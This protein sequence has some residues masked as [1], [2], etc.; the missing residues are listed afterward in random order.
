ML[1]PL[2]QRNN[3]VIYFCFRWNPA[4]RALDVLFLIERSN[5]RRYAR[6]SFFRYASLVLK[7]CR[8]ELAA[9]WAC[10]LPYYSFFGRVTT[11]GHHLLRR[12]HPRK[13]LLRYQS[14]EVRGHIASLKAA[15]AQRM[16]KGELPTA[17]AC[18][19]SECAIFRRQGARGGVA[20]APLF[21]TEEGWSAL[22]GKE[23]KGRYEGRFNLSA[24]RM[25]AEDHTCWRWA[26]MRELSEEF[27]MNISDK[28][29]FNGALKTGSGRVRYF[30][31]G[32]TPVYVP[33]F[34][35]SQGMSAR[36]NGTLRVIANDQDFPWCEREMEEVDYFWMDCTLVDKRLSSSEL[37]ILA[38]LQSAR[39]RRRPCNSFKHIMRNS[40]LRTCLGAL[41]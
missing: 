29:V 11:G 26:A 7:L 35:F 21:W 33:V 3:V 38:E 13:A 2:Y 6:I 41:H 1:V 30:F 22:L 20:I 15:R 40:D 36:I 8:P 5:G 9:R 28:E 18:D 19:H 27:K 23:R 10:Q 14:Q 12:M 34:A 24:G 16:C 31:C 37:G 32:K 39:L 25:K 17:F 4:T